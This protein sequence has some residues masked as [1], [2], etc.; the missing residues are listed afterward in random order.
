MPKLRRR[1]P[2]AEFVEGGK[3]RPLLKR[4]F[5]RRV[6]AKFSSVVAKTRLDRLAC[7][8]QES[9]PALR[10]VAGRPSGAGRPRE[11]PF[12]SATAASGAAKRALS[13]KMLA[14]AFKGCLR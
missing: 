3:E 4:P 12:E 9:P 2:A 14:T 5:F 6:K 13:V 7:I 10:I 11:R 8:P 1:P